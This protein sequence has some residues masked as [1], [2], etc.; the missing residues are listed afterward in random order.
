MPLPYVSSGSRVAAPVQT[1]ARTFAALRHALLGLTFAAASLCGLVSEAASVSGASSMRKDGAAMTASSMPAAEEEMVMGFIVKPHRRAGRRL[2]SALQSRD[3]TE[4]SSAAKVALKVARPMSDD[5]HVLKLQKPVKL[6]EARAIA[7]RMM[8]D[9]AVEMAEP[10]RIM[11]P[12]M[13]PADA[14]YPSQ[15]HYMAPAGSNQGGANLPGAWNLTLG[16]SLINVAVLDTGIRPHADLG[17]VLP[18]YDFISSAKTAN[19]DDEVRDADASDPGDWLLAN[20]C[21]NGNAASNSSWHG[22]HVAGT[23]AAQMNNG[24]GGTGIAPNVRILPVRVLGKCGGATSDIVDAMRW[25]AGIP[26]AGAPTNPYPAQVL[27]MSLGGSGVCSNAFQSAVNDVVNAGKVIVAATGNNSSSTVNQ[28][29]NCTGVIAVTA[30]AIDGDNA[31]YSNIGPEVAISAPGGGCGTM[32]GSACTMFYSANG[33]G[34]F[35]LG[36]AGLTSPGADNYLLKTGTSM[37]VPHVTGVVALML[38]INPSLTPAQVLSHLRSSARPHPAG[39]ACTLPAN[40]G[41]CGAG[42][43][44]A[45]AALTRIAP[46]IVLSNPSQVVEPGAYVMLSGSV[47]APA[48]RTIVS[49]AWTPSPSNPSAV[50]LSGADTPNAAFMAP[51]TGTYLFTL[52]A[53]DSSG[54]STTANAIV[55]INTAPVL[56][57]VSGQDVAAGSKLDFK[58]GATDPDGDSLVFHALSLP[59]GASLSADGEFSWPSAVPAGNYTVAYYAS[60]GYANSTEGTVNVTVTGSSG[61]GGG[62]SMDEGSLVGLAVFAACLRLRRVIKSLARRG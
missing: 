30:H 6:S 16:S 4:L 34:V 12:A 9:P 2:K 48:G 43:L 39:T 31:N 60:D 56:A 44:D 23:I 17:T 26:V 28:P 24:I 42:L 5:S 62:G 18:G 7:A 49:Y 53:T 54:Q 32:S 52:A 57:A 61:G 50:A 8:R 29:A 3:A 35:S 33:L 11:Y 37:A 36:N 14:S 47:S 15:W 41:K 13:V 25:A 19:D 20:E 10:D 27:N 46:V 40:A 21:G 51:L 22:T 59:P 58:V 38:S 1:S 45:E 55:R